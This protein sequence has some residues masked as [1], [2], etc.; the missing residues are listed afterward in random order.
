MPHLDIH[1]IHQDQKKDSITGKYLNLIIQS[2]KYTPTE[3]S[4]NVNNLKFSSRVMLV[5][6][7]A[8]P[9]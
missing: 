6:L 3:H 2:S 8:V 9:I 7:F 4:A 1:S 5:C